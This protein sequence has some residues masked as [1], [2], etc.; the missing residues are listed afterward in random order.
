VRWAVPVWSRC[1]VAGGRGC[2]L[3]CRGR[4]G[5]RGREGGLLLARLPGGWQPLAALVASDVLPAPAGRQ[6][7][8]RPHTSVSGLAPVERLNKWRRGAHDA[9]H[10]G[11]GT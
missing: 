8:F 4:P 1:W 3:S 10:V 5:R 7:R 6:M 9:S 2:L 11:P